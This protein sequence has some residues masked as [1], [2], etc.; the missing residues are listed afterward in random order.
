MQSAGCES[1]RGRA[2]RGERAGGS[3]QKVF[4][5]LDAH[6]KGCHGWGKLQGSCRMDENRQQCMRV[7][8][9]PEKAFG[10]NFKEERLLKQGMRD[11]EWFY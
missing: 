11:R 2:G 6:S 7:R 10:V 3:G 9:F 4:P 1:V 5:V 8:S